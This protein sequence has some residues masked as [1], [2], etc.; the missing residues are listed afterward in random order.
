MKFA[1]T[2][3]LSVYLSVG[4]VFAQKTEVTNLGSSIN[5]IY[6]EL[7]PIISSDGR[8]LYFIRSNH[9]QNFSQTSESLGYINI[10]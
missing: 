7:N 10:F 5:S 4:N 6:S 8:T 9:P 1:F 3:F 2:I